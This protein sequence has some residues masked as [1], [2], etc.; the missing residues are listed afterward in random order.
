[1]WNM[2]LKTLLFLIYSERIKCLTTPLLERNYALLS[3]VVGFTK[4]QDH[5]FPRHL[6][7]CFVVVSNYLELHA[8]FSTTHSH[9]IQS[10]CNAINPIC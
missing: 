1:M 7:S 6:T 4:F 5:C 8:S 3:I 10:T 2:N 9:Q